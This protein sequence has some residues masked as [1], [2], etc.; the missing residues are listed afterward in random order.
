LTNL[1][2][3]RDEGGGGEVRSNGNNY[4]DFQF[5]D[6]ISN[7]LMG[8]REREE[9]EEEKG[10]AQREVEGLISSAVSQ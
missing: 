9:R 1:N 6:T 2:S 4:V 3:A 10:R 5:S 8:K 7:G